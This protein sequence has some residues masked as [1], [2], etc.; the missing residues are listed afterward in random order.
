MPEVEPEE[1]AVV[2]VVNQEEIQ[3][4]SSE[5]LQERRA[6]AIEAKAQEIEKVYRHDCET[7]GMV[8]KMLVAKDPNL[9][10]QLQVPLR[11]SLGEIR[12]RC[13]EDLKQFIHELDEVARQPEHSVCDSTT[14]TAAVL[15]SQ[16]LN[17][18]GLN[19]S[20]SF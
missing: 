10:K 5:G 14:P 17:K 11:E 6:T 1:K 8:V 9:E 15:T 12:E 2:P 18:S 16:K 3:S 13:L 7:F 20:S 4:K 19:P